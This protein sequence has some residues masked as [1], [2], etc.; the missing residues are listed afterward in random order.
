MQ[1]KI[2]K[3]INEERAKFSFDTTGIDWEAL[4]A[5]LVTELQ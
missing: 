1:E 3:V 2:T 5:K 4:I